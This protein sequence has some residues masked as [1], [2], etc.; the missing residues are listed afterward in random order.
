[1]DWQAW[2]DQRLPFTEIKRGGATVW[3]RGGNGLIG[4]S[5]GPVLHSHDQASEIFY[6]ISGRCRLEVGNSEEFF[7]PADFILVPPD[8]PHNLWNAGEDELLV[9]RLVAPN[10]VHNK[11]RTEN[12]V[13]GAMEMRG[14]SGRVDNGAELPSDQNIR[15]QLIRL[16][17]NA[18]DGTSREQQTMTQARGG[19]AVATKG[20]IRE[21]RNLSGKTA[22]NQEAVVYIVE[23]QADVRVG[24]LRRRLKPNDFV[25]VQVGTAYSVDPVGGTVTI[26]L[27]EMPGAQ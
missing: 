22:E 18:S 12:L 19:A 14:I 24:K 7:D 21:L 26:L 20:H 11:W 15:T 4:D 10:F 16:S 5:L 2:I 25:N 13:P 8:V 27:F 23:D 9:F 6:F 1:M 17:P 3:P